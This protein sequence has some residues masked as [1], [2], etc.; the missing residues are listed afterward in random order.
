MPLRSSNNISNSLLTTKSYVHE[1]ATGMQLF[2]QK[3][4]NIVRYCHNFTGRKYWDMA[5]RKKISLDIK[6]NNDTGFGSNADNYGGRFVNKDGSFNVKKEGTPLWDRFS[7]FHT[8]LQLP[9]WKFIF[10]IVLGFILINLLFTFL[11]YLIGA[12]EFTGVIAGTEWLEF[13]ELFFFSTETFSTVG[14]GRVN[15]VGGWANFAAAADALTGSLF[16][17]LVTGLLYG[18]FSRPKAYIKFTKHALVSPYKDI[19]GLMFRFVNTKDNHS[20]TDVQV[21]VSLS[22]LVQEN[23]KSSYKFYTLPLERTRVDSLPMNFTVVHPI[24]EESPV[25]GLSYEDMK[26]ADLELY[27]LVK[28]YDDGYSSQVLQ[29][30]SYTYDEIVFDAKFVQMYRES[31]DGKTT[32]IELH[33]L[34]EYKVTKTVE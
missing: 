15:P 18:R 16:F 34:N 26:H 14:Y 2:V 21:S 5:L 33:R 23:G 12:G 3:P 20:L 31:E 19:T 27:V 25:M 32:I 6:S 7:M 9:A 29:R 17:A 1:K 13:R 4:D 10:F 24:D 8:M 11:F 30:T 22:L 28:A